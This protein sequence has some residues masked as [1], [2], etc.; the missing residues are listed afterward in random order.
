ML[1]KKVLIFLFLLPGCSVFSPQVKKV[2]NLNCDA[3]QF[4]LIQKKLESA[5]RNVIKCLTD[6]NRAADAQS[7]K[8]IL[9]TRE[10]NVRCESARNPQLASPIDREKVQFFA[11]VGDSIE[12]V[13][14]KKS[15][16]LTK[17]W[18]A[19]K[20][21]AEYVCRDLKKDEITSIN[22]LLGGVS[23]YVFEMKNEIPAGA[24]FDIAT[25]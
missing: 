6:N 1:Q 19:V 14:F 11:K 15:A 18:D 8:N 23:Y 17:S 4:P 5:H 13:L 25:N 7:Y 22:E 16:D 24:M 3:E 10:I 20:S 21:R 2:K 12:A 9:A